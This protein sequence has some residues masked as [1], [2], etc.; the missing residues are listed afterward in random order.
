MKLLGGRRFKWNMVLPL[1]ALL[2]CLVLSTVV[3][4]NFNVCNSESRAAMTQ[5]EAFGDTDIDPDPD[6]M[7]DCTASFTTTAP[8]DQVHAY[9][10]R[11]LSAHGWTV[12]PGLRIQPLGRLT[13]KRDN[14]CY[15]VTYNEAPNPVDVSVARKGS[16]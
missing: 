13:G 14:L 10:R 4:R 5:F 9:Y 7:G 15:Y 16:C 6:F 2:G 12:E 11:Q 1:A 8:A 3:Y